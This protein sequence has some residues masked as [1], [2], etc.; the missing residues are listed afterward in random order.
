M[1]RD[2]IRI[3]VFGEGVERRNHARVRRFVNA[4]DRLGLAGDH[5]DPGA[6]PCKTRAGLPEKRAS[7]AWT[8]APGA[9]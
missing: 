5:T 7:M 3:R 9:H 2:R 6:I 1:F 4:V 8:I